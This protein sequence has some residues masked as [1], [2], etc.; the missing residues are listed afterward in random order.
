MAIAPQDPWCRMEMANLLLAQGDPAA[1]LAKAQE[2]ISLSAAPP[3]VLLTRA[4]Q[5]QERCGDRDA[6]RSLLQ[7][8]IAADPENPQPWSILAD[9]LAASGDLAGAKEAAEKAVEVASRQEEMR[10]AMR[11]GSD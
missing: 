9:L 10:Q 1:A 8:A 4:A 6:A 3:V 11:T 2:A 5:I 7:Q